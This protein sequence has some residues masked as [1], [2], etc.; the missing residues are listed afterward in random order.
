M[1]PGEITATIMAGLFALA[2][3]AWAKRLDKA[4]DLLE[5]IQQDMHRTAMQTERRLVRLEAAAEHC[6]YKNHLGFGTEL[7][8]EERG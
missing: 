6:G 7:Q 1:S 5:R 4:L 3:A 2:F 8:H